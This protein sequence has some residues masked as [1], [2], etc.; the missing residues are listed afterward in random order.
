MPIGT[1]LLKYLQAQG[2]IDDDNARK[3][4]VERSRTNKTEE[5]IIR[6][7]HIVND[8]DIVKAK[9]AIF[10]IPFIDLTNFTVQ[11]SVIAE[12]PIDNL[13]K[14]RAVPFERVRA[15]LSR[16]LNTYAAQQRIRASFCG[17]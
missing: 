10:G 14:Y 7:L 4:L 2:L 1:S 3:V 17:F 5:A 9:S 16:S 8:V 11:E 12:V 6:S 15:G 13:N